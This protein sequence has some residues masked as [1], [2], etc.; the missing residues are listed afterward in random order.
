MGIQEVIVD[1]L[2]FLIGSGLIVWTIRAIIKLWL[3]KDIERYKW[4]LSKESIRFSK[5]YE[6]RAK[7]I[8]DLYYKLF[9]FEQAMASFVSPMQWAGEKPMKEK[10]KITAET[11]NE[12]RDYYKRNKIYL[13]EKVSE[14]LEDMDKIFTESWIN[15]TTFEI[16]NPESRALKPTEKMKEWIKVWDKIRLDIPRLRNQLEK[17]F[18]QILGADIN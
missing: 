8:R 4:K 5:L 3:D 17:E 18:R 7:I 1:L 6:E 11:G 9:D 10:R 14:I 13:S 16:D 15:F 12:F 2:Y